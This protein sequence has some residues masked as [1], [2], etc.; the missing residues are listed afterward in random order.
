MIEPQLAA[1][2]LAYTVRLPDG[3]LTVRADREKL[4]Q[5]LLNL[6]SNAVK[7]T[8]P[9]GRLSVAVDAGGDDGMATIRVTDT[10]VG[11]PAQKREAIFEPFVQVHAGPTRPT[12]GAGLGLAISRDLARG[13]GG[14]LTMES[15][16][17]EGSTF[18]V[19]LRVPDEASIPPS[20]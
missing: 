1:K 5:V 3:G 4:T 19:S 11:V 6:L 12:V 20:R 17:G 2:G 9:G 15:V 7:F 14:D 16:E 18:T 8:A 13:M 10:G